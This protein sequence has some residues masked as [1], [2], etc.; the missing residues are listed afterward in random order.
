MLLASKLSYFFFPNNRVQAIPLAGS[1]LVRSL[2]M[3]GL[4]L[5]G[6]ICLIVFRKIPH[7]YIFNV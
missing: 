1:C 2:Q 6:S 7:M 3:E 5:H 4:I